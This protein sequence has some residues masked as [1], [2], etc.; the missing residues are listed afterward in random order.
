MLTNDKALYA[1][2][3]LE[4]IGNIIKDMGFQWIGAIHISHIEN[5]FNSGIV[6][7]EDNVHIHLVIN[8]VSYIDGH[9]F[10]NV[11]DFLNTI[12]TYLKRNYKQL[13]WEYEDHRW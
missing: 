11:Y 8:S 12:R 13:S 6:K 10:H 9:K 2:W 3:V 7:Y 5:I 1:K 4:D